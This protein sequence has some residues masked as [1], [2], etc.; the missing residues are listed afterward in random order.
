MDWVKT[1]RNPFEFLNDE[2]LLIKALISL[3]DVQHEN[4]IKYRTA[5]NKVKQKQEKKWKL[6]HLIPTPGHSSMT[7]IPSLSAMSMISSA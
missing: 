5:E 1:I 2:D 7:T 6:Y 4:A 3:P